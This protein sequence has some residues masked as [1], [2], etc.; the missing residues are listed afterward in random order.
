MVAI[1]VVVGD[2]DTRTTLVRTPEFAEEL[3][4]EVLLGGQLGQRD[5]TRA[6]VVTVSRSCHRSSHPAPRRMP[7]T[8]RMEITL[9]EAEGT[10]DLATCTPA[11]AMD[12]N[13]AVIGF[14]DAQ[15][16]VLVLM[17][18]AASRKAI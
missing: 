17:R 4:R 8:P 14:C 9:L 2:P 6:R 7:G 1:D 11:E 15:A 12:Q 16:R 3:D 13:A 5:S 18:R 10:E